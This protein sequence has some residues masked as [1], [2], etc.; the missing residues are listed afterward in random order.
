VARS[1][2][3]QN[4]VQA[5]LTPRPSDRLRLCAVSP[6]V[7][8]PKNEGTELIAPVPEAPAERSLLAGEIV[9]F[10]TKLGSYLRIPDRTSRIRHL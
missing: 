4:G 7:N 10:D 5:L 6:L 8:N 2:I 3:G 1:G 9:P